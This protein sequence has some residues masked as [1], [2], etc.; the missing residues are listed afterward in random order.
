MPPRP[1][2]R[3]R[4]VPAVVVAVALALLAGGCGWGDDDTAATTLPGEDPSRR[5]AV[6]G[7]DLGPFD[8][9]PEGMAG[10]GT[11]LGGDL[12]V[13]EG[14][15]LLGIPFPDLTGG[16]FRALM[17]V[18]GDPVAVFNDMA[19]QASA[20]G[21]ERVGTCT[22]AEQ[23]L[24]CRGRYV[25]GAD[26]ESLV[27]E[28]R[29]A[30]TELSAVSGLAVRYRPP[31]SEDVGAGADAGA[32]APTAPLAPVALPEVV[33]APPDEDVGVGVRSPL[34]P[35]RAVETGSTLVGLPGPC[36][37]GGEGWSFVVRVEGKVRDLLAAYARQFTDLGEPPDV[38]DR[39]RGDQT[40]FGLRVGEG[41]RVAEIRAVAPEAGP[42]YLVVTVI[43]A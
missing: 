42:T 28:S 27:V 25:D 17:L 32:T 31:G 12:S 15:V 16:G 20:V 36:A 13:P 19:S 5:V 34:A 2:S 35:P 9:D 8:L 18:T 10:P 40:T 6:S 30:V 3:P 33:T 37:C 4:L 29:Q 41:D 38:S 26:G 1:S 14:A 39:F 43:G 21:M 24:T 22:S 23:D 11:P 7:A